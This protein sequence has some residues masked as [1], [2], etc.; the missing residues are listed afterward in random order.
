MTASQ[1][2]ARAESELLQLRSQPSLPAPSDASPTRQPSQG[3]SIAEPPA[4][5]HI[6]DDPQQASQRDGSMS[7]PPHDETA[8]AVSSFASPSVQLPAP[9]LLPR[10][11]S[12]VPSMPAVST[13][14]QSANGLCGDIFS[15]PAASV[16]AP[17]A[18]T[19][20]PP[21]AASA[22]QQWQADSSGQGA[23]ERAPSATSFPMTDL[24][25]GELSVCGAAIVDDMRCAPLS[26]LAH[27]RVMMALNVSTV[28]GCVL[29]NWSDTE[30]VA[31]PHCG[32]GGI[33]RRP[34]RCRRVHREGSRIAGGTR[35]DVPRWRQ[36]FP[37]GGCR[38][39]HLRATF[40]QQRCGSRSPSLWH[41]TGS[42]IRHIPSQAVYR[43]VLAGG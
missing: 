29:G 27:A 4:R 8:P 13:R 12:R 5:P 33:P 28:S 1:L 35:A 2:M 38:A 25:I 42:S 37:V 24:S 7:Q 22:S 26:E 19:A 39:V 21:N 10:P 6:G 15:T 36:S 20:A 9:D 30:C 32:L 11:G 3:A 41:R 34:H 23:G 17:D 18:K 31:Q 14:S 40:L 16:R 43:I